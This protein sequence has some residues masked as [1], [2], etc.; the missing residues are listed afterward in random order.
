MDLLLRDDELEEV[1]IRPAAGPGGQHVNKTSC[2]VRLS[3]DFV[4]SPAIPDSVR[5]R[6]LIQF[7]D[8][9]IVVLSKESRSLTQNRELAR[10]RLQNLL[11]AAFVI[12]K[13]RKKTKVSRAQKAQRRN[14]KAKRAVIK[15]NRKRPGAND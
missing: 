9:K 6:L 13:K 12:P 2:G 1:F 8:G 7:P 3:F 5:E 4:N 15:N 10:I 11:A 14:E